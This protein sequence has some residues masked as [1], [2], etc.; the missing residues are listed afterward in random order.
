MERLDLHWQYVAVATC[1]LWGYAS[2]SSEFHPQGYKPPGTE[3]NRQQHHPQCRPIVTFS[4]F[5]NGAR[6]L[7][8]PLT[9][10]NFFNGVRC[11]DTTAITDANGQLSDR[12]RWP[13]LRLLTWQRLLLSCWL[14][15]E[16]GTSTRA[17]LECVQWLR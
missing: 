15:V 2:R 1:P 3:T 9:I 8:Q 5:K 11:N 12:T 14:F 13:S 10:Y 7:S 17:D 6:G 16:R 4:L